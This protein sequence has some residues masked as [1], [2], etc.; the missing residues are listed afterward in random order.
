MAGW[1]TAFKR[2]L[3]FTQPERVTSPTLGPHLHLNRP[4]ESATFA[5]EKGK[6][7]HSWNS[8]IRHSAKSFSE[9]VVLA[10]QVIKCY[11]LYYF[12]T[13]RG[14]FN[15]D[16]SAIFLVE[17]MYNEAIWVSIIWEIRKNVVYAKSFSS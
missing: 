16:N 1:K 4:L 17:K 14:S 13:G 7:V 3:F 12:T 8:T 5:M 15:Q 10:E 6:A 2:G 11:R 9:N